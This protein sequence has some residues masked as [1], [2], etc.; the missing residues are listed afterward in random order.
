MDWS[1]VG[2]LHFS[3]MV[4]VELSGAGNAQARWFCSSWLEVSPAGL[5][6]G[7]RASGC[8]PAN[9]CKRGVLRPASANVPAA[10]GAAQPVCPGSQ[11]TLP[12]GKGLPDRLRDRAAL[13][14]GAAVSDGALLSGST[15]FRC[16]GPASD[17]LSAAGVPVRHTADCAIS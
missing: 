10:G 5:D 14:A 6:R 16:A 8:I 7:C 4:F 12:L 2:T 9:R 13:P 1:I 3:K 11:A 15:L 17:V